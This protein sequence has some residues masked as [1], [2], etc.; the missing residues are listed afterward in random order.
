MTALATHQIKNRARDQS[1]FSRSI[2]VGSTS[3]QPTRVQLSPN[4]VSQ[5]MPIPPLLFVQIAYGRS[6]LVQKTEVTL[7]PS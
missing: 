7:E 6:T 1:F 4:E 3:F 2:C 5:Q